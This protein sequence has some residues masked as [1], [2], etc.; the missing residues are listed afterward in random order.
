MI[1]IIPVLLVSLL[2]ACSK[3]PYMKNPDHSRPALFPTATVLSWPVVDGAHQDQSGKVRIY[4]E[5]TAEFEDHVRVGDGVRVGSRTYIDE[6]AVLFPN[7]TIGEDS[8]IGRDAIVQSKV[9]IGNNVAIGGD[10]KIGPGS[11][12]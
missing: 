1:R 10:T 12:I 11:I 5:Q 6:D 8:K 4:L 7:V 2:L 3:D 9:R